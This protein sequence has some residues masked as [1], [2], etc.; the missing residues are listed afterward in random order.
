[1]RKVMDH[2]PNTG[3]SHVFYYDDMTDEVTIT[4]EQ[5][6]ST[7]LESNKTQFNDAPTKWGEFDRVATLPLVVYNQWLRERVFDDPKEL[8]RRLNDP[9]NRFF[10][11]RPGNI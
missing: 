4:A 8:K 11:T 7:V 2:D 3:I 6:V 5:D 9:D 10:R 1:M